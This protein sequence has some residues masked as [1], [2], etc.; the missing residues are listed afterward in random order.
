[1]WT[2]VARVASC[3]R[4]APLSAPT[5]LVRATPSVFLMPLPCVFQTPVRFMSEKRTKKV[6]LNEEIRASV[7][8][9]IDE[10]GRM[11]EGVDKRAAVREARGN[12]MDLVQVS[13]QASLK[14]NGPPRVLCKI[15]DYRKK[16]YD[17]ERSA[18]PERKMRG[19]K[20]M[21]Y[22]VD[23]EAHDMGVKSKRVTGFIEKGHPVNLVI[24]WG[25]RTEKRPKGELLYEKVLASI[26]S[27]YTIAKAKTSNVAIRARLN[28]VFK[29]STKGKKE[30]ASSSSS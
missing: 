14:P 28:P 1:M 16:I 10:D 21:I 3:V 6:P 19:D 4:M 13:L 12:G 22:K 2:R 17:S 5:A 26:E 9:I 24:E 29:K 11:R 7:V 30:E 20:D 27:E 25:N 23:I 8:T 15:Y 18:E